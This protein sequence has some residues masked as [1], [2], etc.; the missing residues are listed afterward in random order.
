MFKMR[1]L[2]AFFIMTLL[3]PLQSCK[4]SESNQKGFEYQ[5]VSEI[6]DIKPEKSVRIRL[7]RDKK[8]E[9][10]WELSGDDV[11]RIIEVDKKL[12]GTIRE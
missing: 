3:F 1:L 4:G 12:R 11:D 2:S 9:Y 6:K 5:A 8:G 10:S 7:K